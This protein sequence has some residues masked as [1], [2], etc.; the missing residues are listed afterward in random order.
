[1]LKKCIFWVI[2]GIFTVFY[3]CFPSQS[4]AEILQGITLAEAEQ[5]TEKPKAEETEGEAEWAE[6]A[7][8]VLEDQMTQDFDKRIP[9]RL[10]QKAK[11]VAVFP[12]VLKAGF[13][14]GAK[15]G[16]EA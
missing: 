5:T 16:D 15:R 9:K 3:V 7:A 10:L 11:C 6:K 13:V 4:D 8:N 1:M 14:V 12:S 2:L